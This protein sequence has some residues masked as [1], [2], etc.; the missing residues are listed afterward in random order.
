MA[1]WHLRADNAK[2][3]RVWCVQYNG[4][5]H[6]G[7]SP[8]A[9]DLSPLWTSVA[10]NTRMRCCGQRQSQTSTIWDLILSSKTSCWPPQNQGHHRR[11]PPR[12]LSTAQTLAQLSSHNIS[13][14]PSF[15]T[16]CF[17]FFYIRIFKPVFRSSLSIFCPVLF[18]D[19][20]GVW[21]TNL[22]NK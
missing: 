21:E 20:A 5:M 6:H 13:I 10:G 17:Y 18:M 16:L 8:A 3:N 12:R 14:V 11:P 4:V 19:L 15:K 22:I 9:L 2:G 7:P 1:N